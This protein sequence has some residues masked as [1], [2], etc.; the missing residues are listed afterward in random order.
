MDAPEEAPLKY[1]G[2]IVCGK[3]PSKKVSEY[4]SG[5]VPFVKI[6]DMHGN[7]FLFETEDSLTTIGRDSQANKTLPKYSICVSCI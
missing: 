1:F 3:T 7:V 6:P 4:Y 5:E 2:K